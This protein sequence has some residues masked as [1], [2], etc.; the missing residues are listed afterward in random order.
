IILMVVGWAVSGADLANFDELSLDFN[1]PVTFAGQNLFLA[2]LIPIAGLATW[3]AHGIRPGFVSS[4]VGRFRWGWFA[5]C[6]LVIVP[7]WLVYVFAAALVL[8]GGETVIDTAGRPSTWVVL[9]VL[10]FLT[11]PIQAAGEEYVFRGWL[12]QQVGA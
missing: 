5:W 3:I 8:D 10:T 7:L 9:L 11:T 12:M 1:N 6:V 2:A 4:V